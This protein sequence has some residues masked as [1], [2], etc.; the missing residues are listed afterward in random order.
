MGVGG[1]VSEWKSF[2]QRKKEEREQKAEVRE[3][4][5]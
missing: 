4:P 5:L 3:G 2:R 1:R